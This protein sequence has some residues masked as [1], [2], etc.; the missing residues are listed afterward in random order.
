MEGKSSNRDGVALF[1]LDT[2]RIRKDGEKPQLSSRTDCSINPL[3][4]GT[5]PLLYSQ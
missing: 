3:C 5:V 2:G 1:A 4:G